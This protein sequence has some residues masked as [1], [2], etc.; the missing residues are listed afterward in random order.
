MHATA[1][2]GCVSAEICNFLFFCTAHFCH[3]RMHQMQLVWITLYQQ[4]YLIGW[5][6]EYKP[7]KHEVRLSVILLLTTVQSK[8]SSCQGAVWPDWAIYW[9]LGNFSKSLATINLPK[10][11]AF[12]G[13]FCKGVKIFNFTSKINFGHILQ[14]SGNHLL[15]TLWTKSHGSSINWFFFRHLLKPKISHESYFKTEKQGKAFLDEKRM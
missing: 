15:V 5:I 2:D 12:L 11:L 4:I 8:W 14:T 13:N 3:S 10:S 7:V 6:L 1:T 9:T